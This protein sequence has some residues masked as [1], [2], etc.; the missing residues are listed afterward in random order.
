[1]KGKSA[2]FCIGSPLQAICAIEAI[3]Y[4]SIQTY[5]VKVIDDGARLEQIENFLKQHKIKYDVVAFHSSKLL[6]ILRILA[7][8]F[9]FKGTFDYLIL[10]DFRLIGKRIQYLPLLKRTGNII[11]LDDGN[12][13]VDLVSGK[14]SFSGFN[15]FRLKI[16]KCY[17]KLRRIEDYN[18]FT[19]FVNDIITSKCK[20]KIIKN[21]LKFLSCISKRFSDDIY[22]IGTNPIGEGGYCRDIRIEYKAYL[23]K[24]SSF[25]INVAKNAKGQVF[26]IPHGR[27]ITLDVKAT[28]ERLGIR[29]VRPSICVEL[30]L[31]SED[32]APK[33]IY[34]FGSTSLYLLRFL[35]P[36]VTIVNLTMHSKLGEKTVYDSIASLY[37]TKGINNINI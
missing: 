17:T 30:F 20:F 11:Y 13:V 7:L 16:I 33:V 28:C 37:E 19:I 6:N 26:Y 24:V 29:Y 10:G 27:D 31:L 34:G 3:R 8:F 9:L 12:Y 15:S 32:A 21:E 22:V 23:D 25:L 35:F 5:Q 4:F 2:L 1:M 14:M 18:L 36:N